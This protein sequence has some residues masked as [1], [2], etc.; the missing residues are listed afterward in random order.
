MKFH[1]PH[2]I[3]NKTLNLMKQSSVLFLLFI[4]VSPLLAQQESNSPPPRL[5][6]FEMIPQGK[7]TFKFESNADELTTY[8]IAG[9]REA[10]SF[11]HYWEFG[12]GNYSFEESPIHTY[13]FNPNGDAVVYMT[14]NY[15][16]GDQ[17]DTKPD[18]PSGLAVLDDD[19]ILD[20]PYMDSGDLLNLSNNHD[21]KPGNNMV[22]IIN[23]KNPS[24]NPI[25]G[26]L[27]LFYNETAFDKNLFELTE[28]RVHFGEIRNPE[29]TPSNFSDINHPDLAVDYLASTEDINILDPS[30]AIRDINQRAEQKLN[31]LARDYNSVSVWDIGQMRGREARNL[32]TTFHATPDMLEDTS[33]V[34][35]ITSLFVPDDYKSYEEAI[36]EMTIVS[37]HDPNKISV[38]KTKSSFRRIQSKD[39]T[40]TVHFQNTGKG[41]A[42]TVRIDC[43]LP[44]GLDAESVELKDTHLGKECPPCEKASAGQSCI[45]KKVVS[46]N[47][48]SFTFQNIIL[49]GKD[50]AKKKD[51]TKGFVKYKIK[52]SKKIKK[53]G[54]KSRADIY[55]DKEKAIQTNFSNTKF[56]AGISPAARVAYNYYGADDGNNYLS[57]GVAISPFKSYKWYYQAEVMLASNEG[58]SQ[59]VSETT[60]DL[61]Q[62]IKETTVTTNFDC[63]ILDIVP[64]Q[65]R[66]DLNNFMS[67]GIGGQFSLRSGTE[68]G[69]T[70]SVLKNKEG[71]IFSDPMLDD[72]FINENKFNFIPSAFA[73]LSIGIVRAGP[74]VGLRYYYKFSELEENHFQLYG[75]WK[76]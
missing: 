54:L 39:L 60:Q 56:K 37:A 10:P 3:I 69:T 11:G 5:A 48:V 7:N 34:V 1:I 46:D 63:L 41:T 61:G 53:L 30:I 17:P 20:I 72:E 2:F 21:P 23:Y 65:I 31:D 40:Y 9:S 49:L 14:N 35:T 75:I 52:P 50:E 55:F 42:E 26:K 19:I 25:T 33:A 45:D 64:L 13:K 6:E 8:P 4:L 29:V 18:R 12:D 58:S 57:F 76:F 51:D 67:F 22:C 47:L 28:D 68:N 32:F 15:D 70:T 73:D 24:L 36:L 71:E 16:N 38:S 66:R 27:Y 59:I 74:S 44:E 62:I 43:T